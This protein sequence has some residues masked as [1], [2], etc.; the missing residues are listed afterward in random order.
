[1][2]SI[3]LKSKLHMAR[4]THAKPDY[5]GSLTIDR[6]LMDLVKLRPYEKVLVANSSNGQRFETYA[7]VGAPGSGMICLNGPAT[8][9]GAVGDR[10]VI[11]AFALVPTED[12]PRQKPLILVL[13]E[14]NRPTGPLKTV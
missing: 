2:Y 9:L 3:M 14:H 8:H 4:V 1:M 7:I 13:D 11:L 5:E 10:L 6:E 12:A